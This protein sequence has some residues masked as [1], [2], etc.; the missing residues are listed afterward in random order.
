[1]TRN[2]GRS[3]HQPYGEA[4]EFLPGKTTVR[5]GIS[6]KITQNLLR[7]SKLRK[8]PVAVVDFGYIFVL[9]LRL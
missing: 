7:N 8:F 2:G 5:F 6:Q 3:M 1:M 4:T 9:R